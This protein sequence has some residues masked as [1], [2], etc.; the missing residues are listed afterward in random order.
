ML[1]RKSVKAL[2][3][4]ISV[5]LLMSCGESKKVVLGDIFGTASGFNV[6]YNYPEV[7]ATYPATGTVNVPVDT[8]YIIVFNEPINGATLAGNISI[9]S[10]L[11]VPPLL[12]NGVD[13]N[14]TVGPGSTSAQ[15]AFSY[16]GA[17]PLLASD[18]L[19]F[20]IGPGI[21]DPS[22]TPMTAAM[23]TNFTTGT[24]P[25]I[26]APILILGVGS[27]FPNPG[28][29]GV[30]VSPIISVNFTE[31]GEIDISS[32][33]SSNFFLRRTSDSVVFPTDNPSTDG[34]LYANLGGTTRRANLRVTA[35][36]V[37]ESGTQYT[38]VVTTGVKDLSGLSLPAGTTW[39]FTTAAYD[40]YGLGQPDFADPL[41]VTAVYNTQASINWS[42]TKPTNYTLVGF[43]YGRN[44]ATSSSL[45]D[46]NYLIFHAL[47]LNPPLVPRKRYWIQLQNTNYH[48]VLGQQGLT[49]SGLVQF[50]TTTDEAPVYTDAGANTQSTIKTVTQVLSGTGLFVFWTNLNA[51]NNNLK[52]QLYTSALAAQWGANGMNL[53]TGG[54]YTNEH[55]AEDGTGGS[56]VIASSGN[57]LY[58][59]RITAAGAFINWDTPGP[60]TAG[61]TGLVLTADGAGGRFA[62]V[63]A[64]LNRALFLWRQVSVPTV[65]MV[66]NSI[67]AGSPPA[68]V[69]PE[70]ILDDVDAGVNPFLISDRNN[71]AVVGYVRGGTVY[72]HRIDGNGRIYWG[73]LQSRHTGAVDL[74][75]GT[76]TPSLFPGTID[77]GLAGN[78]NT[79][80]TINETFDINPNGAGWTTVTLNTDCTTQAQVIAEIDAELGTAGFGGVFQAYDAG[81]GAVGIQS[82]AIGAGPSATQCFALRNG[83][84][85]NALAT[86]GITEDLVNRCG[87]G[88]DWS[89]DNQTI[90]LNVDG[91]LAKTITLNARCETLAQVQAE[92]DGKLTTAYAANPYKMV[93]AISVAPN[94]QL[95]TVS[96]G[97]R[98]LNITGG[99]ALGTLGMTAATYR[100]GTALTIS[101]VGGSSLVDLQSDNAIGAVVLYKEPVNQLA[102]RRIT[103]A[104]ATAWTQAIFG[105]ASSQEAMACIGSPAVDVLVALNT[106]TGIWARRGSWA[107]GGYVSQ[108]A[109]ATQQNP[110]IFYNGAN[111]IITW[112]DNRFYYTSA[113]SG[114]Q[115]HNTGWGIFGLKIDATAAALSPVVAWRTNTAGGV[116]DYNG[117]TIILQDY[118]HYTLSSNP[119]HRTGIYNTN[120]S[121]LLWEDPR[122]GNSSDIVYIDLDAYVP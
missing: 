70:F 51:G 55:A 96:F 88:V 4:I 108:V 118:L 76:G 110:Q 52:G 7:M 19:S 58:A 120:Q 72:A 82:V 83:A 48:D 122:A 28:S 47:D 21:T 56:V 104:G 94:L 53:Y 80:G 30:S 35:P 100:N 61:T 92:V 98:R 45:T 20:T 109:G 84:V 15:I 103:S 63:N 8:T 16:G 22:G 11:H 90:T 67:A 102:A 25:D 77:M 93:E 78:H 17:N 106:G 29:I 71:G 40:P 49:S 46:A 5:I 59:K 43:Q 3:S 99:S 27:Q 9:S 86:L 26:T 119:K 95:R 65:R 6:G 1:I 37:L 69:L 41:T 107:A 68:N 112:E 33:N 85:N 115:S 31:A 50:N 10:L 74:S 34:T 23:L 105:A 114:G 14:I 116:D 60:T 64:G 2:T 39:S 89:I 13:Y 24:A 73:T 32:L 79:W 111:T 54:S 62:P 57:N 91:L 12:V 81:G 36:N 75:A 101:A 42:T 44:T 18:T 38:V 117:I 121:I 97:R 113:S 66:I 87:S